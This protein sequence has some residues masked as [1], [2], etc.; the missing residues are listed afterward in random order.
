V[1]DEGYGSAAEIVAAAL[2]AG[3]DAIAVTD[4]NTASWCDAVRT[5]AAGTDLVVLPGVEIST[6]EGHLLGVWEEG[7]SSSAIDDVL[8]V[9]GIKTPDRG[10]LDIAATFGIAG[11]AREIAAGGGVAIAAHIDKARGLLET[12]SVAAHQKR[13]LLEPCLS[14][15]EVVDLDARDTV[16]NKLGGE[17]AMAFV[18]GSDT[19]DPYL[20][21]HALAG[22][23]A[24][25]TWV[26]ASRPDLVGIRHALADPDLRI[27]LGT[28]PPAPAYPVVQSVELVGGFLGGQKVTLCPDLNCLLG[29]TGSGKSLVLE[30]VRYALDQQVDAKAFPAIGEEVQSR[31]K[32]ALGA[33]VVKL[34][35]TAGGQRYRIER[36]FTAAGDAPP[37][38]Y[39]ETGGGWAEISAAPADLVTLAA[40]SQGEVL[41]YS[42]RPVGRMSLIDSGIDISGAQARIASLNRQAAANGSKL[43]AARQRVESL[44]EKAREESAL[45]EQVR[46]LAD[47]FD[48]RVVRQQESWTKES[49]KLSKAANAVS[50]LKAPDVKAPKLPSLHDIDDNRDLFAQASSILQVLKNRLDA[51]ST[52]ITTALAEASQAIE[53]VRSQW[54]TRY[55]DFQARLDAELEKVDGQSSLTSLRTHLGVLQEKLAEAEAASED[56]GSEAIPELE[57]FQTERK[58]LLDSLASVRRE[59]R[60]QRRGRVAELNGKTAGFVRLDVPDHGDFED[61]RRALDVIKVGSRVREDVLDAIARYTHPIRLAR[62]MWQ[63]Q[64]NELADP[65]KGIDAASVARLY[66]N[67]DEKNLWPQLLDLQL[68]DRPDVLT[69]RFKKP[70]DGTYTPIENLAH[71][72]RCTAILIILLADG[73]T[74]VIVDQPEDALHAPWI[75]EYL[76]DRLRALRG[77]RQYVFATRSPGIVVSGDAEQI[78]TLRATAGQG[79]LE[80]SGSLERHDLNR[81]A[82]YHLEGGPVPFSRRTQKLA[83]STTQKQSAAT[84]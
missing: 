26:K 4:H 75:E 70:D 84:T 57:A 10:K 67:I 25:R 39:Q 72:Q 8:V 65:G 41:E 27:R 54:Q 48:T 12:I 49:G 83:V 40:F 71:G 55:K 5:A 51:A 74:P 16:S 80:A 2:S 76:V 60:D 59:R 11:A 62:L 44:R 61:Y 77:S 21:R 17:R 23:G 79:E 69:V 33:G 46:Q 50:A 78:I 82:L 3:L 64:V 20:S 34:Q 56:L 81:L 47:L 42:R 19:W 15:V 28:A 22:I 73:D 31:L 24:R 6:A 68:L 52:E 36:P 9:L 43:I 29:G 53:T 37:T 13:T 66:A 18:Q 63:G 58:K 7:T 35:V 1:R 38:V 30:A 32:V 14:A 45:A